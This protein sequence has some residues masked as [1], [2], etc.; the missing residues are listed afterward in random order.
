MSPALGLDEAQR[1]L[2]VLRPDPTCGFV[3]LLAYPEPGPDGCWPEHDRALTWSIRVVSPV[4]LRKLIG[5]AFRLGLGLAYGLIPRT[6]SSGCLGPAWAVWVDADSYKIEGGWAEIRRRL[7]LLG[8]PPSI[9][10]SS[11]RGYHLLWLLDCAVSPQE[12]SA[13][14]KALQDVK[15]HMHGTT[16]A[17]PTRDHPHADSD[18]AL[19]SIW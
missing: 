7:A 10:V 16:A 6:T 2:S 13:L 8:A 1:L 4:L 11:G 18:H 14:S 19:T 3:H 9:I 5:M 17:P 12:A 15:R